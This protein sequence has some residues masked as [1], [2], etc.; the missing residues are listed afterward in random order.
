MYTYTHMYIY[1]HIYIVHNSPFFGGPLRYPSPSLLT[2]RG[3]TATAA[4]GRCFVALHGIAGGAEF[5]YH[6][7]GTGPK[8]R[9]AWHW[10]KGETMDGEKVGWLSWLQFF[11]SWFFG[12]LHFFCSC[13][14]LDNVWTYWMYWTCLNVWCS[15]RKKVGR[16]VHIASGSFSKTMAML[17]YERLCDTIWWAVSS[18]GCGVPEFLFAGGSEQAELLG[19]LH[20]A[21]GLQFF[22]IF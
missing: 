5:E 20:L 1:I 2:A 3:T 15:G 13:F 19:E 12:G 9:G 21:G 14:L 18:L 4:L 16:L 7:H 17:V 6:G 22:P 10:G 8:R 11:W